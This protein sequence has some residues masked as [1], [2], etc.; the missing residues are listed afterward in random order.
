MKKFL[1]FLFK[2][3]ITVLIILFYIA[4][5]PAILICSYLLFNEI[6]KINDPNPLPSSLNISIES[7]TLYLIICII[8]FIII[9]T[10]LI[11]NKKKSLK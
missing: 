11:I 1:K 8:P 6:D 4:D 5:I 2:C 7:M 10:L 9:T 3:S